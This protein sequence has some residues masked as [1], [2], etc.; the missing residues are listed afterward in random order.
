MANTFDVALTAFVSALQQRLNQHFTE[1]YS[2]LTPPVV[3]IERGSRYVRVVRTER[4]QVSAHCFVRIA[5]G[6]ILKTA[7]WKAPFIAKGGPNAPATVRGSIYV[8]MGMD[9]VGVYGTNYVR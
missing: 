8:N 6:A 9:A 2:N 1:H 4:G 5:D 7:G 3:G